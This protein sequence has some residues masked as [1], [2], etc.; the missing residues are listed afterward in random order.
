M[1]LGVMLDDKLQ[2]K[3]QLKVVKRKAC[4]DSASLRQ[5]LHVL[6]NSIKKHIYNAIVLPHLDQCLVVWFCH[7][8]K[9]QLHICL[10]DQ[11]VCLHPYVRDAV[12]NKNKLKFLCHTAVHDKILTATI[13]KSTIEARFVYLPGAAIL[14]QAFRSSAGIINSK[15]RC[16]GGRHRRGSGISLTEW[17]NSPGKCR[18]GSVH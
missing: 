2:W 14:S 17:K 15:T 8:L 18:V 10:L 12:K 11:T 16:A 1:C 5:L 7:T 3:E 9:R 4:A 6:P 13:S